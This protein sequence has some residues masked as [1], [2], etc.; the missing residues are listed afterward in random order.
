MATERPV[1]RPTM[2]GAANT[3][4]AAGRDAEHIAHL[5]GG[6]DVIGMVECKNLALARLAPEG[7]TAHQWTAKRRRPGRRRPRDAAKAG[8]GIVL[9]DATLRPRQGAELELKIGVRPVLGRRRVRMLTRYIACLAV[10]HVVTGEPFYLVVVHFPPERFERLWPR[11][12]RRVRRIAAR[13]PNV[14][15]MTDANMPAAALVD[16][17]DLAELT[18]YGEEVMAVLWNRHQLDP[19][20]VQT[21][22]WGRRHRATGHPTVVAGLAHRR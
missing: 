14:V 15:I 9:R 2:F 8:C 16:L 17:L 4:Y 10:E 18:Y 12:V 19:K 3:D 21:D 5:A 7:F 20:V 13:H 6:L 11:V 22:R 1:V